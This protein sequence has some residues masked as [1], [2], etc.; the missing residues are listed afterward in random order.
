MRA[1]GAPIAALALLA[2]APSPAPQRTITV[3]CMRAPFFVWGDA[4]GG[5]PRRAAT[6]AAIMGQRFT[7]LSIRTSLPGDVFYETDAPAADAGRM[8]EH[9]WLARSCAPAD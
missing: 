4:E 1:F 3:V 2:A 7:L 5:V 6:D 8:G 9:L